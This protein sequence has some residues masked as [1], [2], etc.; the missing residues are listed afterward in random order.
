MGGV[1]MEQKWQ[2]PPLRPKAHPIEDSTTSWG[3]G[4]LWWGPRLDIIR[5]CLWRG[6]ENSSQED[7]HLN[8]R[9]SRADGHPSVGGSRPIS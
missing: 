4:V 8:C 7:E 5:Q 2:V 6:G 3:R 9:L 1:G